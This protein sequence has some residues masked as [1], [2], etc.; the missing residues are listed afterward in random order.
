MDIYAKTG[1]KVRYLAKNGYDHDAAEASKI[2]QKDSIYTVESTTV[3][4]WSSDVHLKEFPGKSFN[5]VMFE[6]VE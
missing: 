2:L 6:D 5:S 4:N 1:A 3:H